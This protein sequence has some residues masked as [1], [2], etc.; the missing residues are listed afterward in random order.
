ME[1]KIESKQHPSDFE[2]YNKVAA[3]LLRNAYQAVIRQLPG[4]G[5]ISP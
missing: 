2:E 3:V 5:D 4:G 1:S